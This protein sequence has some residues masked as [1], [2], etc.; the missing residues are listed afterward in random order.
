MTPKT[1]ELSLLTLQNLL[2]QGVRIEQ[3]HQLQYCTVRVLPNPMRV[4]LICVAQCVNGSVRSKQGRAEL[5]LKVI[6]IS[7]SGKCFC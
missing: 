3:P 7:N 2:L 1:Y 6:E 5:L 4:L